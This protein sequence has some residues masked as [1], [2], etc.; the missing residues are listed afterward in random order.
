MF[1]HFSTFFMFLP[2]SSFFKHFFIVL[3]FSSFSLVSSFFFILVHFR[4]CFLMFFIIL[5]VFLHFL[6]IGALVDEFFKAKNGQCKDSTVTEVTITSDSYVGR[7][8]PMSQ[9]FCT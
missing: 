5:C 7:G 4:S 2:F 3:Q 8:A 1:I 6:H 9:R